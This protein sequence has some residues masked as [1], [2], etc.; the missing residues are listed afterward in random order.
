MANASSLREDSKTSLI[1]WL[2][3]KI[4]KT[5]EHQ[6]IQLQLR[7]T[8]DHIELFNN[9]NQC[10]KYITQTTNTR[11]YFIVNG[12]FDDQIISHI[13]KFS[14]ILYIYIVSNDSKKDEQWKKTFSKVMYHYIVTHRLRFNLGTK[15]NERFQ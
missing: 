11:V 3:T 10:E 1:V 2:D 4:N 12:E 5:E 8:I 13:H 6:Q 15:N 9:I 14:Q 7:Q